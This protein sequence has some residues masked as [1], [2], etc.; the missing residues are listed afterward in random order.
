MTWDS[1]PVMR[2][3]DIKTAA[4][5]LAVWMAAPPFLGRYLLL[6]LSGG[7]LLLWFIG[8]SCSKQLEDRGATITCFTLP[9]ERIHVPIEKV[10]VANFC[11]NCSLEG[12]TGAGA[13][14][15]GAVGYKEG[16][17]GQKASFPSR[18]FAAGCT[19]VGAPKK[20]AAGQEE[21]GG[22][23]ET[24]FPSRTFAAGGQV[25]EAPEEGA[26]SQEDMGGG[27][28]PTMATMAVEAMCAAH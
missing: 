2:G 11:Y 26:S 24:S 20:G 21:G 12:S 13:S 15:K 6:W 10:K 3:P 19:V 17:G 8:S 16:G 22:G 5:P 28:P 23:Q 9:I 25:A 4:P 27:G 7:Q 18:T 14:E 1:G